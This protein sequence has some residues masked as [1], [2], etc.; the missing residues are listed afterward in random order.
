MGPMNRPR[1]KKPWKLNLLPKGFPRVDLNL[2]NP[3]EASSNQ[4][5]QNTRR[6][7]NG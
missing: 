5:V 3:T 2:K 7:S 1:P 6:S 4:D